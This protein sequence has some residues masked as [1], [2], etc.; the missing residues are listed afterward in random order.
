[1]RI[2]K[3]YVCVR[4][5]SKEE[6]HKSFNDTVICGKAVVVLLE[7]VQYENAFENKKTN[8]LKKSPE[9]HWSKF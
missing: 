5:V 4:N 7:A 8:G 6:S 1:M 3:L 2:C 9:Y